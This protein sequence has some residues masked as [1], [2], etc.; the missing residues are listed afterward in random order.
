MIRNDKEYRKSVEK[1]QAEEI[2]IQT[3]TDNL[4][5]EG[6]TSEEIKRLIDPVISFHL[7]LKEEIMSYEKLKRGEFSELYN[8]RGFGHLLVSLRIA[9][10]I[11]QR[12]LADKLGVNEAQISRDERNEYHNI[13]ID[14]ATK[15]I[16]VLG[17]SLCSTVQIHQTLQNGNANSL[18]T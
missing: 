4:A 8:F 5:G 18:V 9:K 14:R 16:D 11:T 7:Q 1:V 13:T 2:R 15:I 17:V 10:G 12:E 6:Y 3:M